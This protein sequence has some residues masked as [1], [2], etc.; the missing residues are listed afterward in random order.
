MKE[1]EI[2]RLIEREKHVSNLNILL[3]III[4]IIEKKTN[5]KILQRN[6]HMIMQHKKCS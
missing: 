5:R 3:F 4:I 2:E 6:F 1:K